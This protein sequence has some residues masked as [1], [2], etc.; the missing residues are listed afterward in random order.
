MPAR[1]P[2]RLR[3]G[4]KDDLNLNFV[5]VGIAQFNDFVKSFLPNFR[6]RLLKSLVLAL[7]HSTPN[8]PLTRLVTLDALLQRNIKKENHT[9]NLEPLC[10]LEAFLPRL[11]SERRGIHHTEPVQAEARFGEEV[12]ESKRLGLKTLISLVVAHSCARPVG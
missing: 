12:D 10:Q 9:G 7:D 1:H 6:L 3:N 2:R 8:R 5:Q 11:G 4:P